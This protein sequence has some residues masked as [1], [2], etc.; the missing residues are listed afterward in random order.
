M[1]DFFQPGVGV[2]WNLAWELMGPCVVQYKTTTTTNDKGATG[3]AITDS[4][5]GIRPKKPTTAQKPKKPT[6]QKPSGTTIY[7]EPEEEGSGG[8]DDPCPPSWSESVVYSQGDTIGVQDSGRFYECKPYPYTGK[9][10]LF[11]CIAWV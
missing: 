2:Y 4:F 6:A 7:S 10:L 8:N 11:V 5:S 9:C 3:T 1:T